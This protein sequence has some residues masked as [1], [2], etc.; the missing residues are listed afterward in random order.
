MDE[1]TFDAVK[2]KDWSE[3]DWNKF[4]DWLKGMLKQSEGIVTFTKKDGS[5]RVMKCTLNPDLLPKVEITEGKKERKV[6]EF[7]M[8]VYDLDA[9]GWRS[10]SIKSVKRVE[11]TLKLT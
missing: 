11:I 10:F 1:Y 5:E 3:K 8:A 6:N 2:T 4:S 7:V 9:E